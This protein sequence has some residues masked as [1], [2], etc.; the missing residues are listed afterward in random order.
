MNCSTHATEW[1]WNG[2]EGSL[3]LV[4]PTSPRTGSFNYACDANPQVQLQIHPTCTKGARLTSFDCTQQSVHSLIG[5][6]KCVSEKCLIRKYDIFL[7]SVCT[8]TFLSITQCMRTR[9]PSTYEQKITAFFHRN[10]G[11]H[12][13]CI[14]YPRI[15]LEPVGTEVRRLVTLVL[16]ACMPHM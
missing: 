6:F 14:Y 10:A 11:N 5:I 8:T 15:D 7:P 9:V 2:P 4:L 13:C 3:N 1:T 12:H 16:S